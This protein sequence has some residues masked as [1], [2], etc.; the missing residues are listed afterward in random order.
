MLAM[1]AF[2][3]RENSARVG[4][5]AT[6]SM[7]PIRNF[8]FIR[9]NLCEQALAIPIV[10]NCY[11]SKRGAGI[12]VTLAP[13]SALKAAKPTTGKRD[14]QIGWL[15]YRGL[16]FVLSILSFNLIELQELSG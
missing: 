13:G 7:I 1:L 14:R 6:R 10:P 11:H 15:D 9:T 8:R 12:L 3:I 2:M 4:P 16:M 5:L